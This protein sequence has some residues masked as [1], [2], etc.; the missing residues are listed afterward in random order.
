MRKFSIL[1]PVD[2]LGGMVISCSLKCDWLNAVMMDTITR[3][4]QRSATHS[5]QLAGVLSYAGGLTVEGG[6]CK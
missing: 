1:N 5:V 4:R 2:R 3:Y 6:C